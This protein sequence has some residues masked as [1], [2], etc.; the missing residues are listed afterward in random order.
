MS[1]ATLTLAVL[2]LAAPPSPTLAVEPALAPVQSSLPR[3]PDAAKTCV[4]LVLHVVVKDGAPVQTPAWLA[5]QVAEANRHFA[6]VGIGFSVVSVASLPPELAEI[7][8]KLDRDLGGRKLWTPKV[9]HVL[10]VESLDDVDTP[11]VPR[12]G[13]H[14]RDRAHRSHRWIYVTRVAID[15]VLAH[16]IGHFFGLPH[17]RYPDSIMNKTPRLVPDPATWSFA[18]REKPILKA[19]LR[20][21]LRSGQIEAI[22]RP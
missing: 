8:T 4:G 6:T 14:W 22:K 5:N 20:L 11:G 10:V 17:S 19:S 9:I 3:C 1:P 21:L 16:E 15:W 18:A 2:T 13:V 12:L 7:H